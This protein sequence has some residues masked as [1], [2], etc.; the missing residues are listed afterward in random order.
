[1]NGIFHC[2]V[3]NFNDFLRFSRVILLSEIVPWQTI[4]LHFTNRP[5]LLCLTWTITHLKQG[6]ALRMDACP[7]FFFLIWFN[8]LW[9][10]HWIWSSTGKEP[11]DTTSTANPAAFCS[12]MCSAVWTRRSTSTGEWKP[13]GCCHGYLLLNLW[14]KE[15]ILFLNTFR[16]VQS[17]GQDSLKP[18]LTTLTLNRINVVPGLDSPVEQ[19]EVHFVCLPSQRDYHHRQGRTGEL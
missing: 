9:S 8:R 7:N 16:L 6:N 5:A 14:V 4:T 18:F 15:I 13:N 11:M 10:M 3:K 12:T 17:F 1:M 19:E 2:Q